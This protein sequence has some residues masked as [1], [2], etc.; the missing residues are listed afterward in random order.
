[1]PSNQLTLAQAAR[2][3]IVFAMVALVVRPVGAEVLT[4]KN[5]TRLEGTLGKVAS[6]GADPLKAG[7][8]GDVKLKRV[9]VVDDELRRIFV[10]THQVA[11]EPAPSPATGFERIKIDQRKAIA[12]RAVGS[13][14]PI[15]R[16]TPFDEWGRR[17]FS[18]STAQGTVDIVQGI[19]EVTPTY[20]V[21]EALQG[22]DQYIWTM[23]VATS[24]I[25]RQTLSRL[26]LN[27]ITATNPDERLRVVR[28]YIQADRI[29]DARAELE[30]LLKDFPELDYLKEQVA[31]L[32]QLGAQRLLK[33]IQL[34]RDSGQHQLAY[35]MLEKFPSDG[36]AGET[37]IKVSEMMT[38]Y[39]DVRGRGE[40]VLKL[41]AEHQSQL[42]DDK[43]KEEITPVL[44]EIAAELNI[45]TLDRM[46]DYLRLA[47][48]EKLPAE[49]KVSLAVS[50]WMLGSGSGL[51]NLAVS[52]SLVQV[53]DIVRKYLAS[54]IK[55]DRDA[56]LD[57]LRSLEG[58][59]TGNIAKLLA[60]MKPP[61][62][63]VIYPPQPDA[64]A[65][66]PAP[67]PAAPVV[68]PI[69]LPPA[70]G[71]KAADAAKPGEEGV[72]PAAFGEDLLA[73][74]APKPVVVRPV[75]AQQELQGVPEKSAVEYGAPPGLL[76]VRVPGLSEDPE[77]IYYVQLPPE[78]DPYKRYPVVVSLSGAGTTPL[79]QIDWWCGAYSPEASTRYGQATRFGYIVIAP[80]WTREHQRKYEFSAREHAAVLYSLR[81]AC[82]RFSVD[83]DRVF[84]SG[85]SMG[86]DA[87]WDIS[88]AHPDL[89]AGVL[90]VVATSDKYVPRYWENGSQLPMYFVCGEKDGNKMA[91]NAG[92]W[93]R[94]LTRSGWDV[95]IVQY[96]GR[97]H[98]HYHDE[99]QRMMDWMGLHKRN[100]FPKEVEVVTM[101]PWDNFF[102]WMELERMPPAS[103]VVPVQWPP[104]R[105]SQVARTKGSLTATNG[106]IVSSAAQKVT[107]W[108]SPE[109][110][111]FTQKILVTINNR[112][113]PAPAAS[114]DVILEDARTR[115]DRLH[116]FWAKVEN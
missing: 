44:A 24:S 20:T 60:H 110:V 4:L 19:T 9:I 82:K 29:Q 31:T 8:A 104:P 53:R 59:T 25:P 94:Y 108:L 63:T 96:Q 76:Q 12:G 69:K 32:N 100:F 111:D 36:V 41:L 109:M 72:R 77:I 67:A 37:L 113:Q 105:T 14:G 79:Q 78:Y 23:R 66:A 107:V 46:S 52:R 1:M 5:G 65:D 64:P 68:R 57:Q 115:A 102:W 85:H 2:G 47:D 34:R 90:P 54:S 84:L 112:R 30:S 81:D 40:Q 11:V 26:L 58:A 18:M 3:L 22:R 17:I 71:E 73:G 21:V 39:E 93:D 75:A 38:Q 98:E 7:G 95:T 48:D 27:R 62:E 10:G 74:P 87:A 55:P 116:P 45:N 13:V 103:M 106:V 114:I 51:D 70:A 50:G 101:R 6:L 83:T 61:I 80:Q 99:I 15:L 92:D 89:W 33:E 28:L 88:L 42:K 35:A 86:G 91:E 56:L 97:G 16:V 43:L 49:Q